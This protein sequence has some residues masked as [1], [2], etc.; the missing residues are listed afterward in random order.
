M[1]GL[2]NN[3]KSYDT[4]K[5]ST[6]D[7]ITLPSLLYQFLD[8]SIGFQDR[9]GLSRPSNPVDVQEKKRGQIS[10]KLTDVLGNHDIVELPLLSI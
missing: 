6:K 7:R 4:C 8:L 3:I 9:K 1:Q 2:T 5:S 10:S